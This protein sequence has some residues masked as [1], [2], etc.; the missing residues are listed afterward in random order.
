MHQKDHWCHFNEVI[1]FVWR[2]CQY[3]NWVV[4]ICIGLYV[5]DTLYVAENKA[6]SSQSRKVT[7]KKLQKTFSH[8]LLFLAFINLPVWGNSDGYATPKITQQIRVGLSWDCQTMICL[9][10]FVSW[11]LFKDFIYFKPW[12]PK[13]YRVF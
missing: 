11:R 6:P 3:N 4:K 12:I 8:E 1:F 5:I 9:F 10:C 2:P 7:G 13:F